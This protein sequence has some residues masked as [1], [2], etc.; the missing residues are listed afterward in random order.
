MNVSFLRDLVAVLE[1]RERW[2]AVALSVFALV[3]ALAEAVGIGAVLPFMSLLQNS[4][5]ALENSWLRRFYEISGA[6]SVN[7]LVLWAALGLLAIFAVKNLLLAALYLFQARFAAAVEARL[8][9]DL[10]AVYL[11]APYVARL[12]R[13]SADRL[14]IVNSEVGRVIG[15]VLTPTMNGLTEGA[16]AVAIMA[17]LIAVHPRAALLAFVV[18]SIASAITHRVV[19]RKLSRYRNVR[20]DALKAMFKWVSEGIGA[21]KDAKVLRKEQHFIDGYVGQAH[22]YARATEAFNSLG[23]I[24]RLVVETVAVGALLLAIASGVA[25]GTSMQ[26]SVPIIALFGVAALRLL[27]SATR[28]MAAANTL[29]FYQPSV[30]EV[31]EEL[32]LMRKYAADFRH[33]QPRRGEAQR[34]PLVSLELENVSFRY[35]GSGRPSVRDVNLNI[36][37]G[38]MTAIMGRSGSGKTTLSDLLLGLLKPDTGVIRLNGKALKLQQWDVGGV[39]GSVPQDIFVLDNTVRRNVAFGLAD[40]EIDDGRVWD[41]LRLAQIED[42]IRALPDLLDSWL[43]ERGATL[44]GGER[45]RLGIARALYRDP[46]ILVLDE[47]TSALDTATEEGLL[48]TL[49]ALAGKK[50][51][52]VVSHRL[53]AVARCDRVFLMH[54]G[55]IVDA[56]GFADVMARNPEFGNMPDGESP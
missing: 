29:R 26:N 35:P 24:P 23:A 13:N 22:A 8:S 46:E 7:E 6:G 33:E 47:A 36:A 15:G 40:H 38:K 21:L 14:R 1:P 12:E 18:I 56:G 48:D 52:V 49:A 10:Y 2:R 31:A 11:M 55:M 44:S 30:R 27:P 25:A 16:A 19:Q 51:I 39:L 3:G 50:T 53:A 42:R 28:I 37:L 9:S 17:L 34:E 32:A 20:V 43:G 4:S 5:T 54:E 41:A 45:Q